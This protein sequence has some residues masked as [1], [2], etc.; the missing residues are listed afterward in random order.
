MQGFLNLNK[1]AGWTS[2]DCV[3]KL[4]RAFNTRQIGHGGTLDPDATGVLPIAV[5]RA[6]RF[7]QFLSG[8]KAYRATFVLG[9]TSTTDDA[10][11]EITARHPVPHLQRE[12]VRAVLPQFI[13]TI[14]QI[15]PVYSAIR[16]Q[17]KRLY[18][19]AR[20]GA[21]AESLAL[22]PRRV[23]IYRIE[24]L[25]WRAGEYAEIDLDI[26]CGT[27][28]YI[29]AIA[30]DL[31]QT[32]GCGGL[33]SQL[34]RTQSGPFHDRDS[35]PLDTLLESANPDQ[36]LSPIAFAFR[37]WQAISLDPDSARRWCCGQKLLHPDPD[38]PNPMKVMQGDRFLGL[39]Q[40]QDGLLKPLR[41][42]AS[43][44]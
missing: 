34:H 33:M 38:N 13:G 24:C 9:Q 14:A 1:P 2:H 28:T 31:G 5:G 23:E 7:L 12:D 15:P 20:A 4:R 26:E 17:G 36:F 21:T 11:G 30:R 22:E 39:A 42:L 16:K 44:G 25:A 18:E 10:S 19:L 27:G 37:D 43:Q 32:L 6:T 41:V 40:L 3:G 8:G 29:R 35:I